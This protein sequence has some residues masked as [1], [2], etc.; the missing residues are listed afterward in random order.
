MEKRTHVPFQAEK[1]GRVRVVKTQGVETK[2]EKP[3]K[4]G[5]SK[6]KRRVGGK[7]KSQQGWYQTGRRE[8][9]KR[10]ENLVH[11]SGSGAGWM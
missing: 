6:K 5:P 3:T 1:K 11:S 8:G 4:Y 2:A 7:A 9:E 10:S